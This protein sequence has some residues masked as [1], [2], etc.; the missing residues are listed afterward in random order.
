MRPLRSARTAA[1]LG[2]RALTRGPL[3][4]LLMTVLMMSLVYVQLLFIP[5]LIQGAVDRTEN[6]LIETVTSSVQVTPAGAE[7]AIPDTPS[8]EA[9]IRD[10]PGVEAVTSTLRVGS[11]VAHGSTSGSFPVLAIDPGAYA[12]VFTTPDNLIEGR[13][14]EPGD[15]GSVVLGIGVA[16]ADLDTVASYRSSLRTVHAGDRVTVTLAD[17]TTKELT[18][19]GVYQ[20]RLVASDGQAFVTEDVVAEAL[21]S[22]ADLASAI[23]VRT[24]RGDEESVASR[25][26]ALG[27]DLNY[28]TWLDLRQT[29]DDQVESFNLINEILRVVSLLVAAATV[30]IVTYVDLVGKRRTIGIERAIGIKSSA[31][32][33]SY[34][35]KAVAYALA[36]TAVGLGILFGA[37]VP[38]IDAHPFSFPIGPVTLSVSGRQLRSDALVLVV[39][40][41]LAATLPAWRTARVRILDAI[42]G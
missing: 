35:L 20:N 15:T 18:V 3:G 34:V 30:V 21:P 26:E 25:L 29:I 17:G 6:Q 32:V 37:V 19:V 28:E 5:S 24:D 42:W 4:V 11:E 16:G 9:E 39:V 12:Q 31:I 8:L 1:F 41:V 14:L 10:V 38:V 22:A 13:W 23:H 7:T 36:G 33:S 40:A 2:V 27:G